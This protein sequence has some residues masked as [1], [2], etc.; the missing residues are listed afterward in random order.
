MATIAVLT[1]A[2]IACCRRQIATDLSCVVYG[3]APLLR[4]LLMLP[5]LLPQQLVLLALALVP[6]LSLMRPLS[7]VSLPGD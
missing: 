5:R 1:A 4:V 3:L 7:N 6:S 2:Y